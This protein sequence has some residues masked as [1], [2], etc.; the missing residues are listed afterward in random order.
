M[1]GSWK[2]G[3]AAGIGIYVHWTFLILPLVV[4]LSTLGASGL[5]AAIETVLFILAI[6]GCVVLHELGHALAARRYGIGTRDIT[7]LP[8][9]G[10]A[11]LERMPRRPIQE[12]VVAL[13]GPAVNV[14]IAATLFLVL[15]SV[16]DVEQLLNTGFLA[17]SFL[18]Q[19]MLAN[20]ALVVFNLLPAFPMD[21][22][23]VVRAL[24]ATRLSY[25]RATEIAAGIGQG[26]AVLFA[27]VG[28]FSNWTLLL[29]AAF[30]FFAARSE[31]AS[32]QM[33][34]PHAMQTPH[35]MLVGDLM[36]SQFQTVGAHQT[37]A[38]AAQTVL[39][40]PQLDFPVIDGDRVVGMLS[41]RDVL[42]AASDGDSQQTVADVMRRDVPTVRRD[43]S[44]GSIYWQMRR[45]HLSTVPV[46]DRGM[47]VGLLPI[48]RLQRWL[49]FGAMQGAV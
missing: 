15:Q 18:A 41:T 14:A 4:G 19:L 25:N 33:Q 21:G 11:R 3:H 29:V 17:S 13:A 24:L 39:Y 26:M 32:V 43:D 47:L 12:L 20:I 34:A 16:A 27:I 35:T 9:G 5:A 48:D 23:R 8:I 49:Q 36:C 22:G 1:R 6:F 38:E 31:A 40:S 28:L 42:L 45:G 46:A 10:V 30:V 2:L 44:P 7:L 37:L